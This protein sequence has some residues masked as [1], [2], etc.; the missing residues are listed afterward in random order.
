MTYT[1][2]GKTA[3]PTNTG[4]I[5]LSITPRDRDFAEIYIFKKWGSKPGVRQSKHQGVKLT[6][7]SNRFGV[8]RI[9]VAFERSGRQIEMGQ[10]L[11]L[12]KA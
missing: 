12:G 2:F 3:V 9:L 8:V 4:K 1:N 5:I 11:H 10:S 6:P 7:A